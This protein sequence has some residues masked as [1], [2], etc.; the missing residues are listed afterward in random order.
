[1]TPMSIFE[2]FPSTAAAA[3]ALLAAF[4]SLSL[5]YFNHSMLAEREAAIIQPEFHSRNGVHPNEK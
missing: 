5:K 2:I 4:F 1:M 3:L